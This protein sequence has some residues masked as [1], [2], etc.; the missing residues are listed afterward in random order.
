MKLKI[1]TILLIIA[2]ISAK[3]IKKHR[4]VPDASDLMNHYGGPTNV[5]EEGPK[6]RAEQYV[7]G[8]PEVFVP[9]RYDGVQLM[10]KSLEFKGYPGMENKLNPLPVK[11]GDFTNVAP[12]ASKIIHPE[13]TGPKLHLQTELTYP[14]H[15]KMP[16]FY[17]F[18][19][20]FHPV[21]A[22]DKLEGRIIHDE[23]VIL[24]PQYGFEDRVTNISRPVDK[25]INLNTGDFIDTNHKK[26]FHGIDSE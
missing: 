13:I 19:K 24:K 1:L 20:E 3:K 9:Q 5:V 4:H 26:T 11:S 25:F 7:E 23:A 10:H 8:N 2:I 15:V 17:G 12:S 16:T 21:S 22:Y 14:S 6:T 18:R